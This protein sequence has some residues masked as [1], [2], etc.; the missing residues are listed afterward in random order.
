MPTSGM[1]VS[2]ARRSS[3]TLLEISSASRR[4]S[5]KPIAFDGDKAIRAQ[6]TEQF[7]RRIVEFCPQC[8]ESMLGLRRAVAWRCKLG[9]VPPPS[10]EDCARDPRTPVF[11]TAREEEVTTPQ[12]FVRLKGQGQLPHAPVRPLRTIVHVERLGPK[13][14]RE[15]DGCA[16]ADGLAAARSRIKRA[17]WHRAAS[18]CRRH[19]E[20]ANAGNSA[21]IS[22]ATSAAQAWHRAVRAVSSRS[23]E[24]QP[25]IAARTRSTSTCEHSQTHRQTCPRARL[26]SA[27]AS[28]PGQPCSCANRAA[29]RS[30][31][32]ERYCGSAA[33]DPRKIGVMH[34]DELV[35][36]DFSRSIRKHSDHGASLG[37]AKRRRC[38]TS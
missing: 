2:I 26:R 1:W 3:R 31:R 33:R 23:N 17:R 20:T 35:R 10:A 13:P 19:P 32:H 18:S 29:R 9:L 24:T 36:S 15:P 21:S 4:R 28:R 12:C 16:L 25:A 27:S 7:V 38:A 11:T 34:R 37:R 6:S 8:I 5:A 14:I 22:S 30:A